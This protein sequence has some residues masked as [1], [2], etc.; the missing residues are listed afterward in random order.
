VL[1]CSCAIL[2]AVGCKGKANDPVQ[3][4][5]ATTPSPEPYREV[6]AEDG[7]RYYS[8]L[9][10]ESVTGAGVHDEGFE[11]FVIG[12]DRKLIPI[13]LLS[14]TV[15]GGLIQTRDFGVLKEKAGGSST[16]GFRLFATEDQIK[17]LRALQ[18]SGK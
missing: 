10:M 3:T 12:N 9:Q 7:I 6:T 18:A 11:L 5:Q 1:L 14:S 17:R 4:A 13:P 16:V 8:R 15:D 2:L